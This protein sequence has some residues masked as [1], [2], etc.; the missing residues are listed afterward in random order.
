MEQKY[1]YVRSPLTAAELLQE[2]FTYVKTPMARGQSVFVFAHSDALM[3]YLA[4][5]C[6]EQ[7][8]AVADR[9][10]LCF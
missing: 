10:L 5:H 1:V 9:A 4:E 6:T 2:G 3:A 8:Y 7:D